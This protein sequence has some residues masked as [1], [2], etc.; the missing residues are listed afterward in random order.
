[1]QIWQHLKKKNNILLKVKK[2]NNNLC[3]IKRKDKLI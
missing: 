1:M 3:N 2:Q